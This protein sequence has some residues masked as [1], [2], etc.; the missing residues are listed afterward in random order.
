MAIIQNILGNFLK[1][2]IIIFTNKIKKYI[3]K[4]GK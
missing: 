1:I 2:N 4:C 3:K